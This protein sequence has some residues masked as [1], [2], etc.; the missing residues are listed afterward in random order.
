[1]EVK[2]NMAEPVRNDEP[3]SSLRFPQNEESARPGPVPVTRSVDPAGTRTLPETAEPH[4]PLGE[5]PE[6]GSG[7]ALDWRETGAEKMDEVRENLENAY[8]RAG[9]FVRGRMRVVRAR[10]GVLK[11]R[12]ESGELQETVRARA[13]DLRDTASRQARMARQRA[14]FYG[15]KYPLQVIGG[16]AAAAFLLGFVLRMWRDE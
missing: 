14:E 3:L 8:D 6:Q 7:G 2:N 13:E 9:N 4:A 1:M 5:W 16:V 15:R 12:I 10:A 11:S